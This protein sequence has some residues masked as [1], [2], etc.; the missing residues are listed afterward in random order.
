MLLEGWQCSWACPD[1]GRNSYSPL[2]SHACTAAALAAAQRR[3]N[4]VADL[5]TFPTEELGKGAP[6]A[7]PGSRRPFQVLPRALR[8]KMGQAQQRAPSPP[9]QG[10][11]RSQLMKHTVSGRK[12]FP[13]AG[14]EHQGTADKS[15]PITPKA[16]SSWAGYSEE[17]PG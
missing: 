13:P 2:L 3:G 10:T 9:V 1:D 5:P 14:P 11:Q 17:A 8:P 4:S 15:M 12:I 6:R 16:V 7:A